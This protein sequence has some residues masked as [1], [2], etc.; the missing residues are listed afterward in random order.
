V[1]NSSNNRID[2]YR[3]LQQLLLISL[4][5]FAASSALEGQPTFNK[6][7][8]LTIDDG[9]SSNLIRCI[10][11]DSRDY[12][13]VGTEEGL[14]KYD[15]YDIKK[16]RFNKNDQGSISNNG[17]ICIFEDSRKDLWFGT[18]D[19]LNKYN[20]DKD[21]FTVY[22]N[23]PGNNHSLNSSN[24]NG[25]AEDKA[26]NI[27]VVTGENCL[28][29][30][31]PDSGYFIRYRYEEQAFSVTPRPSRMLAIDKNGLIWVVSYSDG[32]YSFNPETG[33]FSPAAGQIQDLGGDCL[34]SL[35]I[36]NH[37]KIWITTDGS[38]LFAY[39]P[40]LKNFKQ[41]GSQGG[42]TGTNKKGLLDVTQEDENHLLFAV[43]QGGI[44]RLDLR[45]GKFE[46]LMFDN[47]NNEGLNNNGI[48]CF[49][50]DREGILWVGTSGGGINYHNPKKYKFHLQR[51]K[52][53]DPNSLSYNNVTCFYEDDQGL[54][55]IGTDG[56]GL[57]VYNPDNETFKVYRHN[58]S[59]PFSISGNAIRCIS[60][61]KDKNL[62]IG[63]WD[64]GLNRFDRKSGRFTVYMPERNNPSG[65]SGRNVWNMAI[66]KNDTIWL[67]MFNEGIDLFDK[68]KG[69]V[70]RFRNNTDRPDV[71]IGKNDYVLF[72]DSN[73]DIWVSV[74]G[75]ICLYNSESGT[76]KR[77]SF[78]DKLVSDVNDNVISAFCK[79]QK[80]DL[81][82]GTIANGI[83]HCKPDGTIIDTLS[84][85][86]GLPSKRIQ[87]IIEGNDGCLWISSNGGI[88]RYDIADRKFRN[89]T[90]ADGLQG[91]QFKQQ[92]CLKGRNGKLYFG[93]FN[94]FNSFIPDSIKDNDFIP[95]VYIT[96]FQI[97]NQPVVFGG[98][99][100][101]FPCPINVAKEITLRPGQSVF[102][103]TFNAI[104]YTSPEKNKYAYIMEGFEH[105][106]NN[107]DASRRY[108]TYT[109][110]DPG[111][112][113]FRV[114]ATNNDGIWNDTGVSLKITILPPWWKTLVFR[115]S[116]SLFVILLFVTF[117]FRRV[118][119]LSRQKVLL[120]KT[121]AAKTYELQETNKAL[122][123]QA[124][125]LSESNQLLGDRQRKIEKQTEELIRQK[126]I[127]MKLNEELNELNASK[128][129]FFS[130]IAHDLKN[131]FHSI[132]GLS[133]ILLDDLG[134][135]NIQKAKEIGSAINT[136]S[137]ETFRLLE[138]LLEWAN[139]Q[140][141]KI[142]FSP[143]DFNLADIIN[144][145]LRVVE[146]MSAGKNISIKNNVND[147]MIIFA[148][149]NMLR[150]VIRNL[151]TNAIKFT[152]RNGSVE[153]NG[154]V[155]A[156]E[157]EISVTD[158]GIGMN[159]GFIQN[160]FRID[161]G[162]S[163]R[164][165]ENEKGTGLGLF[166]CK[167]FVEKHNGI[168]SAESSEGKGSTFKFRIPFLPCENHKTKE[169]FNP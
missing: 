124:K 66:D 85:N 89:Y 83:F 158:N 13:W 9:L 131:P 100:S 157:W 74:R 133:Y 166:L 114:R 58:P 93:G 54:I 52:G 57:N 87:S 49:Y 43:D 125:E 22:K 37:N 98:K 79:D 21:N 136:S 90:K 29:K 1:L 160:L 75:G 118:R 17:L 129:K 64:A 145:E 30:W 81:W 38:G 159:T 5:C 60:E 31:V 108:V 94:G 168:I 95:P 10:F 7:D 139:S 20:P 27:W 44:N 165:T 3:Y 164:G 33:K 113:T 96:G 126:N 84:I 115:I 34:K 137:V 167:E 65:L 59:D 91:D 144:E 149:K 56:G 48:W 153:I 68:N 106:W 40:V 53:N 127:L 155:L 45:T 73:K 77:I 61:D 163:T 138:N 32:F 16:Y 70:K 19:G 105:T 12:L 26:G 147:E 135:G 148:D 112:Y 130:I 111:E 146:D 39:D 101:Q 97:F 162:V 8:H 76:F 140:R 42:G 69:V 35:F 104:N 67:G 128:D 86:S 92:S 152:P 117:F 161:S 110:L 46:Y 82:V 154:K 14:D 123:Q 50:K 142:P 120:E 122:I 23:I 41:Y 143:V 51:N 24:I 55:W 63:T 80:G 116:A 47:S 36:D 72:R 88:S 132:I 15:S 151:L 78:H 6:F 18:V 2:R 103:F 150:T 121:V 169:I 134:S 102:S 99:N 11:R 119:Q 109:H 62:W 71:S 28:N 156:E 141:G 4:F 25:I 107:T